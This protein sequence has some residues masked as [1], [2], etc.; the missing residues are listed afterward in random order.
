MYSQKLAS[1]VR[2]R[3]STGYWNTYR[4]FYTRG[5]EADCLIV[6]PGVINLQKP[7]KGAEKRPDFGDNP[8]GGKGEG[9]GGHSGII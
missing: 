5:N 1:P 3:V 7:K 4:T 2:L 8:F 9:S 6:Y